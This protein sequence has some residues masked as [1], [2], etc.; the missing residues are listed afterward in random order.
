MHVCAGALRFSSAD[1]PVFVARLARPAAKRVSVST[2]RRPF[3]RRDFPRTCPVRQSIGGRD[4]GRPA[5][6]GETRGFGKTKSAR[7]CPLFLDPV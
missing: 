2:T 1:S 6:R 7:P 5:E 3:R 4:S